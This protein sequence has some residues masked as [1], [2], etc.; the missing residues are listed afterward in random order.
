M[1]KVETIINDIFSSNTYILLNKSFKYCWLVDIG[2]YYKVEKTIPK[3]IEV[4][5]VLLT[6]THYD[7]IYGLNALYLAHPSCKVYTSSYGA[8][9]L[10]DDR[11]NLSRYH[12]TSFTFKGHNVVVLHEGDRIELFPGFLLKSYYTPGHCPSCLTFSVDNYLFT[13]DAYIPGLSVVISLPKGDRIQA[14]FSV[15][16]IKVLAEGKVVLAG[17][18]SR[19][20]KTIEE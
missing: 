10:Y 4:K 8:Q 11:K 6:H 16:K 9:A 14:K 20:S 3:D 19:D 13:G 15:D 1:L 2:D 12:D 18:G 5:G 17:H 7:H